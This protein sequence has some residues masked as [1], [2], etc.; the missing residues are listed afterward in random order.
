MFNFNKY[1]SINFTPPEV[2]N[3]SSI[4]NLIKSQIDENDPS[5]DLDYEKLPKVRVLNNESQIQYAPGLEDMLFGASGSKEEKNGWKK[6]KLVI[7]AINS[8]KIN[9]WQVVE[10]NILDIKVSKNIDTLL[11]KLTYTDFTEKVKNLFFQV[12]IKGHTYEAVKWG[13]AIGGVDASKEEI[14]QFLILARHAEFTV[15]VSH[16]IFRESEKNPVYKKYL[17]SLL[18]S[19]HQW[20]V[21]SLIQYIVQDESLVSQKETQRDIV[22][23]GMENNDGIA[24]EIGFIIAKAINF[25]SIFSMGLEDVQLRHGLVYLMST[26]MF[27]SNP[28]GGILD[29]DNGET[30]LKDYISFLEKLPVDVIIL[31]GFKDVEDFLKDDEVKWKNRSIYLEEVHEKFEELYDTEII[32]NGLH[33]EKTKWAALGLIDKLKIKDL[34]HELLDLYQKTPLSYKINYLQSILLEIGNEEDVR[35]VFQKTLSFIDFNFRKAQPMSKINI[36]GP[37]HANNYL[38]SSIIKNLWRIPSTE[39]VGHLKQALNDYDPVIRSAACESVGKL[40][41]DWI[42]PELKELIKERTDDQPNYV[43]ESAEEALRKISKN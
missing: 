38:Y 12:A 43:K 5:K 26:L 30:V 7:D 13:I 6:I 31:S 21:V 4:Y 23:Y 22:V 16:V 17:I 32:K 35:T 36:V 27:E 20:G 24:M 29:L 34:R 33:D 19:T 9:N 25:E 11:G 39:A 40:P 8:G 1:K 42:D 15:Y 28:L 18:P 2:S 41:F 10:K 14:E 3:E 37:K